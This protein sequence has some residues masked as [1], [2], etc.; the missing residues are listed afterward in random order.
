M[1]VGDDSFIQYESYGYSNFILVSHYVSTEQSLT[2]HVYGLH[3]KWPM[4]D[5][6]NALEVE[7]NHFQN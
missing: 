6:Y 2:A 1:I 3:G 4:T 7:G 5:R